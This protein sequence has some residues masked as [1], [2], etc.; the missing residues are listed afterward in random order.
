[1]LNRNEG[2]TGALGAGSAALDEK[3]AEITA[4]FEAEKAEKEKIKLDANSSL[5]E[6]RKELVSYKSKLE[7]ELE[8]GRKALEERDRYNVSLYLCT[9]V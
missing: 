6:L 7:S 4:K 3:L 2:V 5:E 1:M 8:N 9:P